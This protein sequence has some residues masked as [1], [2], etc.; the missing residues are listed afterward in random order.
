MAKKNDELLSETERLARLAMGESPG[1]STYRLSIDQRYLEK[2][3]DGKTFDLPNPP[4]S[5]SITVEYHN[6]RPV[7]EVWFSPNYKLARKIS[8]RHGEDASERIDRTAKVIRPEDF[9]GIEGA[10]RE[11]RISEDSPDRG[12]AYD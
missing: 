7:K 1:R 4:G 5:A 3:R 8:A 6:C 10:E 2:A 12:E 9:S 11:H